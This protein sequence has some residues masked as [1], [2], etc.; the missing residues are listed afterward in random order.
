MADNVPYLDDPKYYDQFSGHNNLNSPAEADFLDSHMMEYIGIYGND[1][2]IYPVSSYDID[3]DQ[4]FGEDVLMSY[5]AGIQQKAIWELPEDTN[6]FGMFDMMSV[7]ELRI[8]VHTGTITHH[9]GRNIRM[10]DWVKTDYNDIIYEVVNAKQVQHQPHLRKYVTDVI[11]LPRII[12]NEKIDST[13]DGV[14]GDYAFDP[15]MPTTSADDGNIVP[16]DGDN[17]AFENEADN[18]TV[19]SDDEELR[20]DYFGGGW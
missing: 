11:L 6:T 7:D 17:L 3:R 15:G 12:S 1:I 13:S 18:L 8:Q 16:L 10:G 4:I 5:G 9:L 14:D 2:T 19:Q 20:K